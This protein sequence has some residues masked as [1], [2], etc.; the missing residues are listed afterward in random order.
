MTESTKRKSRNN[1]LTE[2]DFTKCDLCSAKYPNA[3]DEAHH[4]GLGL[5]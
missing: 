1:T 5:T 3:L 4:R 2:S